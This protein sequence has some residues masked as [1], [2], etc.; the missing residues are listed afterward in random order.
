MMLMVPTHQFETITISREYRGAELGKAGATD[1][2]AFKVD[3]PRAAM[4]CQQL[5]FD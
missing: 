1:L 2:N 3:C 4:P 5:A